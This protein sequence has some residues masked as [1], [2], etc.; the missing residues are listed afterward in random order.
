VLLTYVDESYTKERYFIAALL[1][2]DTQASSLA[3]A[4]DR[5]VEEACYTYG[6]IDS[7]AELHGYDLV[8]GKGDWLRLA[9]QIRVRIGIYNKA[10]Q[11]IAD[12]DVSVIIRSVDIPRLDRRYASGHD[13]PHSIVLTHLLER[14]DECAGA[15]GELALVIADEV[16][17]QDDYRRDLWDY[18]RSG[19]W[20]Y[21]SSKLTRIV[22]TIHFAPSRA[23]RLVQAADL[24]AY[25]ARRIRT[26]VET[27]ERAK[28]ANT[29]LW[30]RLQ[31]KIY[32]E[33]CWYP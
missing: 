11:A 1:V 27:D 20:G 21:R 29:A 9:P 30:A 23:S 15:K 4:L 6:Q 32:H 8:S 19:T 17:D 33:W 24:I 7:R 14:I 3:R 10:L 22:D 28:R 16:N 13:H 25:M 31:P 26:H 2:P 18:Q 12:H 5:I